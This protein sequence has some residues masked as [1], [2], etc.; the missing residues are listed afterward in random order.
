[1]SFKIKGLFT[2]MMTEGVGMFSD[3]IDAKIGINNGNKFKR[4][5]Y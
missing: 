4:G 2:G 1:M 3:M 5:Y